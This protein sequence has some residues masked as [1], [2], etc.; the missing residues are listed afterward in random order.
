LSF[1]KFVLNF[2]ILGYLG[3]IYFSGVPESNTLN[4][5]LR[6]MAQSTA[7]ALGIW[8]SW[9]MFAP[10]PIKFDSKTYVIISYK[11]GDIQEYDVEIGP[12]GLFSNIRRARWRKY[13]QDRLRSFD[14]KGLLAPAL[15]HFHRKYD[16]PSNPITNIRLTRKWSEVESYTENSPLAPLWS[17][18]R[19]EKKEEL[20]TQNY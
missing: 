7:L 1:K 5:R 15:R 6:Q 9:S 8:P 18:L 12:T 14:Q 10:D 3:I 13:A 19:D 17:T 16:N 2:L 4:A 20:I 11:D